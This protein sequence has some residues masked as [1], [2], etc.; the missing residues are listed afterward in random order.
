MGQKD[1]IMSQKGLK[2]HEKRQEMEFLDQKKLLFSGIFLSGIRGVTPP[3]FNG[4][5]LCSK[6][7]SRKGG[8]PPPLSGKIR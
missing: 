5:S 3:P 2:M 8:Y 7:L 6:R 4:Q 1:H